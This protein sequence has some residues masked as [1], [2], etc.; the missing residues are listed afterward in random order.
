MSYKVHF[1]IHRRLMLKFWYLLYAEQHLSR[2]SFHIY[3]VQACFFCYAFWKDSIGITDTVSISWHILLQSAIT[4]VSGKL[5]VIRDGV[6]RIVQFL[7][8]ITLHIYYFGAELSVFAVIIDNSFV[9]CPLE[10]APLVIIPGMGLGKT[11][12]IR[13]IL[14]IQ[15][16]YLQG[17]L[18]SRHS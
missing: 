1:V 9:L 5:S 8:H 14:A 3:Q 15:I 16:A 2:V 7:N 17:V 13:E 12:P 4:E 11:M 18:R 6:Y 10:S